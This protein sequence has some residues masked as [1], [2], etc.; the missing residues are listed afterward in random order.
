VD[1]DAVNRGGVARARWDA[2]R[3]PPD[4]VVALGLLLT[5]AVVGA[6][7]AGRWDPQLNEHRPLSWSPPRIPAAT[8]RPAVAARP[9]AGA[10]L[11]GW[12]GDL[13]V[14]LLVVVAAAAVWL[15]AVLLRRLLARLLRHWLRRW[16]P[17]LSAPAQAA[18]GGVVRVAGE[19]EPAALRAGI[20][21]AASAV[22]GHRAPAE[23]VV[24]AWAALESAAHRSGLD[25]DPAS[26]PTEFTVAVLDRTP[27]D[28]AA[29]RT[30]LGLYLRA[31]F[32]AGPMTPGDVDTALAA[33]ATLQRGL[34]RAPGGTRR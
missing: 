11:P 5:A 25:R 14:A 23:G 6:A 18:P 1:D 30:L 17:A 12:V 10:V 22:R 2:A 8:P 31:R 3:R 20:D 33:L 9:P 28:P 24:A 4:R 21:R 29:T 26:T 13:A 27:A 34:A 32:G 19:P 15:L 16:F 7:L